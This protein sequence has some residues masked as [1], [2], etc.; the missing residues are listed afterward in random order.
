MYFKIISLVLMLMCGVLMV[1]GVHAQGGLTTPLQIKINGVT[2]G[3]ANSLDFT[4]VVLE[5]TTVKFGDL[6]GSNLSQIIVTITNI[7]MPDIQ[8]D[9][10]DITNKFALTNT[11]I[12]INGIEGSLSSNNNFNINTTLPVTNMTYTST[13]IYTFA[14][15]GSVFRVILTNNVILRN[16]TNG[17]DGQA[18]TWWIRQDSIGE[19][20][21]DL[22]THFKV[23]ASATLPLS[24]YTNANGMTMFAARYDAT[25]TNWY[26]VSLVPGY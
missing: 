22:D 12:T 24:W 10:N 16:P 8:D 18:V 21:V 15:S 25:R 26:V 7:I 1:M 2:A 4:N 19:H 17:V 14:D 13:N 6:A 9:I 5:G 20:T 23:P 3:T 11:T